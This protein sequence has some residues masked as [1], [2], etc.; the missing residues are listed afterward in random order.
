MAGTT[1][2]TALVTGASGGIGEEYARQL[3]A[4]DHDLVAEDQQFDLVGRS[5][6]TE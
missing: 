5:T 4:Q 3:A 6:P 1:W 2:N